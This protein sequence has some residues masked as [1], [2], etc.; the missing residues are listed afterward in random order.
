MLFVKF[1]PYFLGEL[2]SLLT[3]GSSTSPSIFF[4]DYDIKMFSFYFQNRIISQ[5]VR[6]GRLIRSGHI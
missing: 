5:K 1:A 4:S 6:M 2:M 3:S